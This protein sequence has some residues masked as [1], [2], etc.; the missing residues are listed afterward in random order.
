MVKEAEGTGRAKPQN[1]MEA[2]KTNEEPNREGAYHH[3][4]KTECV[5][6]RDD[7]AGGLYTPRILPTAVDHDDDYHYLSARNSASDG[8]DVSVNV[9]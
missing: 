7:V 3:D 5:D 6:S 4:Q 1:S 2:K 8:W 9:L